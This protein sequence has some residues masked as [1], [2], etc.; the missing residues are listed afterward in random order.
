[1]NSCKFKNEKNPNELKSNNYHD[2]ISVLNDTTHYLDSLNTQ[3]KSSNSQKERS[4]QS[5]SNYE[6]SSF[7]ILEYISGHY[8]YK[9][10][11][12]SYMDE[13]QN[14]YEE[15]NISISSDGT[16]SCFDSNLGDLRSGR[17]ELRGKYEY[18]DNEYLLTFRFNP[19]VF[20]MLA[21]GYSAKDGAGNGKSLYFGGYK[22]IKDY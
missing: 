22:L 17:I 4:L 12:Q 20:G 10:L 9:R 14:L 11:I 2:T 15:I 6:L 5:N 3:V 19:D 7:T 16:F 13:E 1:M 8:S 18:V 21:N